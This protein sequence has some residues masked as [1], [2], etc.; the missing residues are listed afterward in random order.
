[1]PMDS[2]ELL[3]DE[4]SSALGCEKLVPDE[5]NRCSFVTP[6]GVNITLELDAQGRNLTVMT[7]LG[8]LAPGKYCEEVLYE[9]LRAND[10][11]PPRYG[12]YAYLAPSGELALCDTLAMKNLRGRTLADYLNAFY[13]KAIECREAIASNTLPVIGTTAKSAPPPMGLFR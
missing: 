8:T 4:L 10:Q 12:N 13:L 9:G 6:S 11:P 3:L 5:T 2:F 1:M 7:L